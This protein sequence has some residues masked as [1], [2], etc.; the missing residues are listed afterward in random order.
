MNLV[1]LEDCIA[2]LFTILEQGVWNEVFNVSMDAH[3]SR[4]DYYTT[5]CKQMNL[6]VPKFDDNVPSVGKIIATSK[7][8]QLLGYRFKVKL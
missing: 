7:L 2:I 1:H 8:V 6:P 3:P 4:K 5:T